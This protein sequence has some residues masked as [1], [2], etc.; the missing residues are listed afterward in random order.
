MEENQKVVFNLEPSG[1][2]LRDNVLQLTEVAACT[3]FEFSTKL[4][5]GITPNPCYR[6]V[7]FFVGWLNKI[8]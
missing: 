7:L 3:M 1:V 5:G 8:L 4:S 2:K 6:I